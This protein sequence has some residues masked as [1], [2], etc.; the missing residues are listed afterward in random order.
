MAK[1]K[2]RPFT[3]TSKE[4]AARLAIAVFIASSLGYA[5]LLPNLPKRGKDSLRKEGRTAAVFFDLFSTANLPL[6]KTVLSLSLS[7]FSSH[8]PPPRPPPHPTHTYTHARAR[9]QASPSSSWTK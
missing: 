7:F 6:G 3:R 1:I 5:V 9:A 8:L 2:L 4:A